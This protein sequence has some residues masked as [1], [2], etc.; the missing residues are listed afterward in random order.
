[1]SERTEI[2]WQEDHAQDFRAI[3]EALAALVAVNL[4][5]TVHTD[6]LTTVRTVR[7]KVQMFH[8]LIPNAPQLLQLLD[9]AE[10]GLLAV[11]AIANLA[12]DAKDHG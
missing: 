3:H 10:K 11:V 9:V 2:T 1:V 5:G 12:K 6:W 7:E 8:F 4:Q